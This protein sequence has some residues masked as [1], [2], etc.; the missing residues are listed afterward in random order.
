MPKSHVTP[1][2]RLTDKQVYFSPAT[3]QLIDYFC[4]ANAAMA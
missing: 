1:D 4:A 2:P 3:V